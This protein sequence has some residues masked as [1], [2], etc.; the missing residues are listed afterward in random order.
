MLRIGLL[1]EIEVWDGEQ[2]L[3]LPPSRKTRLLLAYLA[4]TARP[5]RRERLCELLWDL[6]DDPRAALRWSLTKL[7]S[8]LDREGATVIVADRQTV[9]L[10]LDPGQV[11]LMEVRSRLRLGIDATA[12]EDLIKAAACFRGPFLAD[13]DPPRDPELQSWLAGLR[14]ETRR[15]HVAILTE[16]DDR[17]DGPADQAID[18][19]RGLVQLDPYAEDG[20]ARLVSRL[21]AAG[22]TREAEEQYAAARVALR[23]VGGVSHILEEA[24][25]TPAGEPAR[26]RPRP[27]PTPHPDEEA[28][29]QGPPVARR[30]RWLTVELV[31]ASVALVAAAVGW[32]A[33]S[34][35]AN[36]AHAKSV[37][38]MP[39]EDFSPG[40]TEQLFAAGLTEEVES[41]LAQ[42][43]DIRVAGRWTEGP[44]GGDIKAIA[45]AAGVANVLT[46]SVRRSGDR[47]R[48][49]VDRGRI[50]SAGFQIHN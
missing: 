44:R 19:A 17:Q 36:P 38:V 45:R 7:R 47:L 31:I 22:H 1:G 48:V 32:F 50:I 5:Q 34:G 23:D 9:A 46:G 6:P 4:A 11:D 37:A 18:Y 3:A 43:P 28:P 35:R 49:T 8:L 42:T 15:L 40:K 25:A 12:T 41:N 30:R 14:E 13:V 26:R 24:A 10:Q 2:R 29:L 21:R 27:R 20:W 33:L 16:L 39:F